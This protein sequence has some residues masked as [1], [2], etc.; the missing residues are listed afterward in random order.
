MARCLN[1]V[2]LI[3]NLGRD[4]EVK[5]LPGGDTVG[6]FSVATTEYFTTRN[7]EQTSKTEWHRIVTF[8]KLADNCGRYLNKG[9][10]VFVEG[11]LR[12]REWERDGVK[13]YTTEVVALDVH[14]LDRPTTS[15]KDR[16]GEA[17]V[18]NTPEDVLF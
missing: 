3:G 8:G 9:S 14:F 18:V 6:E 7:G 12:T 1:R 15:G 16:P 11:R 10:K 13:R 2:T 4:P 5:T 17:P